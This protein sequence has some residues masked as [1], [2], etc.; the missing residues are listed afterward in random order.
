MF[1]TSKRDFSTATVKAEE[2]S[3]MTVSTWLKLMQ[4]IVCRRFKFSY[5]M[6][7]RNSRIV[8]FT[9]SGLSVL[10]LCPAPGIH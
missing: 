6:V 1:P 9:S 5:S 2:S 8:L 10:E 7:L 3:Y 4:L